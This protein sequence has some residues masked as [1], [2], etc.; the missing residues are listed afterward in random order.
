MDMSRTANRFSASGFDSNDVRLEWFSD[1]VGGC[2]VY[3]DNG[4]RFSNDVVEH[5]LAGY[6]I[7]TVCKEERTVGRGRMID[8]ELGSERERKR[9]FDF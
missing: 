4:Q 7:K 1:D 5:R 8:R 2:G 6:L 9:L 3:V